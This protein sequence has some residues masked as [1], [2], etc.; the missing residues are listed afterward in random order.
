MCE[1][2]RHYLAKANVYYA[3]ACLSRGH[4]HG[5]FPPCVPLDYLLDTYG[6]YAPIIQSREQ[7]CRIVPVGKRA[8]LGGMAQF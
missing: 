4:A 1:P 2:R 5:H 7:T 6:A 8:S 3:W